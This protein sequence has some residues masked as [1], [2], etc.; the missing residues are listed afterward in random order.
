MKDRQNMRLSLNETQSLT[1]Y[2][3][4]QTSAHKTKTIWANMG[5][6]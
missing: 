5:L 1:F 2:Q 3:K 6:D 4:K